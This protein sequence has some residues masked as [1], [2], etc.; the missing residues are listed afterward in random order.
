MTLRIE[1]VI[2]AENIIANSIKDG[3]VV[4]IRNSIDLIPETVRAEFRILR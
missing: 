3:V 4:S 1:A 2:E